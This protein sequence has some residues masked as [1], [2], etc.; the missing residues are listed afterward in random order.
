LRAGTRAD[1]VGNMLKQMAQSVLNRVGV[2]LVSKNSPE[3]SDIPVGVEEGFLEVHRRC[4]PHTL[5][6]AAAMYGLYKAV[7]YIVTNDIPGDIAECGVFCGGSIMVCAM[8][9]LEFGDRSR[10][11]YL[12]D[13]FEGMT[14]P[15]ARDVDVHGKSPTDHLKVWGLSN[16]QQMARATLDQVKTNLRTTGYPEDQFIF[17]KGRVEDT[18]PQTAAAQLALLR[19]DTDWHASTSHELRNLF[20]RLSP[21]GVLI[22]DDYGFWRGSREACDEYFNENKVPI[23]LTR[24][25][26]GGEVIGVKP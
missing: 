14:E 17:V 21:R 7:Q 15:T 8:A 3:F 24:M 10:R 5:S 12:Y 18:I 9:L 2:K 23:L 25:G 1:S 19:L 26:R 4:R 11:L 16:M 20:P 6:S 13:T 22:V